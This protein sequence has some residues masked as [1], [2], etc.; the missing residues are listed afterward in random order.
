MLKFSGSWSALPEK[1]LEPHET[2][3]HELCSIVGRSEKGLPARAEGR[4]MAPEEITD[5]TNHPNQ[6]GPTA[7]VADR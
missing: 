2:G 7:R 6:T 5:Q 1:E 3:K 4:C